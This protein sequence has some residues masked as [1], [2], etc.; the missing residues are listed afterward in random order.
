MVAKGKLNAPQ[1]KDQLREPL[2][3]YLGESGAK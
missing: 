2:N 1:E 3:D